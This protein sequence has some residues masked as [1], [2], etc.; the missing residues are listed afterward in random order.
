MKKTLMWMLFSA[1][2]FFVLVPG[3]VVSLPPGGS[4]MVKA[5]THAVV[6]AV[7]YCVLARM[8]RARM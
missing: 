5:L 1:A 4:P 7:A 8:L 3:V 2:L 6:F